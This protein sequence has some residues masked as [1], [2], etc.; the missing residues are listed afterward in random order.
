MAF[1]FR[2]SL[3]HPPVACESDSEAVFG[4]FQLLSGRRYESAEHLNELAAELA[5]RPALDYRGVT[6]VELDCAGKFDEEAVPD[7]I[8]RFRN[9]SEMVI[10][11]ECSPVDGE[12]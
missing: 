9:G 8:I 5:A 1:Y 7:L 10:P 6:S 3:D 2:F 12:Q 4:L 11:C